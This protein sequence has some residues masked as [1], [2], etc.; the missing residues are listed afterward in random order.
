M[1][2]TV[3]NLRNAKKSPQEGKVGETEVEGVAG[4]FD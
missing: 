4:D 1:V 2:T 3:G